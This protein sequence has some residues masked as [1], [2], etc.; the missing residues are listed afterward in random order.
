MNFTAQAVHGTGFGVN[1]FDDAEA[2]VGV[3]VPLGGMT[4]GK[5]HDQRF[6]FQEATPA[7][8]D[9]LSMIDQPYV[10]GRVITSFDYSFV[11]DSIPMSPTGPTNPPTKDPNTKLDPGQTPPMDNNTNPPPDTITTGGLNKSY[12]DPGKIP[13]TDNNTPPPFDNVG[14]GH[15]GKV[16]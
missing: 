3:S 6:N 4:S 5:Y 2:R 13:P 11:P 9:A 8:S 15:L 7:T 14:T 10:H 1:S 16:Y 12:P